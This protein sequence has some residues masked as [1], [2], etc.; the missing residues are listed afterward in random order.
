[1]TGCK[2]KFDGYHYCGERTQGSENNIYCNEC[3]QNH[4]KDIVYGK[5]NPN[6]KTID[7]EI[8]DDVDYRL[9]LKKVIK[10]VCESEGVD[11]DWITHDQFY[12]TKKFTDCEIKAIEALEKEEA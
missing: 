6:H 3:K 9:L 12:G 2:K 1:M 5:I 7:G 11:S 10:S 8:F 4:R